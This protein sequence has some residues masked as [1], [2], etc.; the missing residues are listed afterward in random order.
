MT[1]NK[2]LAQVNSLVKPDH[3]SQ[4]PLKFIKN[5]KTANS[6]FLKLGISVSL[7]AA[8]HLP[9]LNQAAQAANLNNSKVS[10]S[11]F[12]E[13]DGKPSQRPRF[14]GLLPRILSLVN[15]STKSQPVNLTSNSTQSKSVSSAN[16]NHSSLNLV[17]DQK[18]S[19]SAKLTQRFH[20]V[21]RGDTINQIANKYQVSRIELIKLNQIK[22]SN[23]IFVDQRLKIPVTK[24]VPT[25]P[26]RKKLSKN[27]LSSTSSTVVSNQQVVSSSTNAN[28]SVKLA[29]KPVN[30]N[31]R[32]SRSGALGSS[33]L[34]SSQQEIG[35]KPI[36]N[37]SYITRLKAEI[38]SLRLQQ[39]RS[40]SKNLTSTNFAPAN[41]YQ[42]KHQL[43]PNSKNSSSAVGQ[44]NLP[45]PKYNLK[46][47]TLEDNLVA[48]TLPPLSDS[49]EYLPSA[50][51][52]YIWPAQ[53][54]LTSG[55]GWR[56]GRLH[57]GID[58]AAPVGTPVL[59]A[60][61]GEVIGA[62]WHGGYGNLIKLEHL[63]GSVTLYAHNNRILVG[64]GQ[65]V[66]QGEQIA[67]MGN[68]GNSTGSHLHFEIHS[69]DKQ[70]INP[71]ALLKSR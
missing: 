42:A 24:V 13:G 31:F 17:A 29:Q 32:R 37:D 38:E 35:L 40:A 54:V 71:L 23:I 68:T 65:R 43:E 51:D 66:N 5:S 22:N 10:N 56:W 47:E 52:G 60:A 62:G 18:K 30:S 11:F 44:T 4:S 21:K 7:A 9:S 49:Q 2:N 6:I 39:K 33:Q 53:G 59:A 1:L 19:L 14:T 27:M 8:L 3:I 36:Q 63:D 55:Y 69:R 16:S 58:I 20:R 34:N 67:E 64:H 48:L 26:E 46:S 28:T 50:F 61:S 41:T 12:K 70:V 25:A 15:F 57:S 45:Q